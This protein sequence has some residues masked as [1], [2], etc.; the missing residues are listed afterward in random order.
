MDE[1]NDEINCIGR[2]IFFAFEWN[3]FHSDVAVMRRM[4]TRG[5]CGMDRKKNNSN[6]GS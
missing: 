6:D 1:R 3:Q 5:V 2:H 4:R